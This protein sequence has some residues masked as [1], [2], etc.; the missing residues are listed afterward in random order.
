MVVCVTLAHSSH[1]SVPQG[2]NDNSG[3]G[4]IVANFLHDKSERGQILFFVLN[5]LGDNQMESY[6]AG[7]GGGGMMCSAGATGP[8]VDDVFQ[9]IDDRYQA[10]FEAFGGT[11]IKRPREQSNTCAIRLANTVFFEVESG[12]W[13]AA[14]CHRSAILI[15]F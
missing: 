7:G 1:D 6:F 4:P 9:R 14:T 5:S 10:S 15:R 8:Q 13:Y 12:S 3:L 11:Y 2:Y